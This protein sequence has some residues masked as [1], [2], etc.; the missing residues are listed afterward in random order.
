MISGFTFTLSRANGWVVLRTGLPYAFDGVNVVSQEEEREFDKTGGYLWRW[1]PW[2]QIYMQAAGFAV[3]GQDTAAGRVPFA[4]AALVVCNDSGLMHVAAALDRPLV[5]LY[6]SSSPGF[7]PPL[8]ARAQ[9]VT[10]DL[11]CSP[12]FARECPLGH[13]DCL[14]KLEP[15]RVLAVCLTTLGQQ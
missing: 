8:S 10:L 9:I 4:L 12:C 15:A 5:A 11:A 3:G 14:N 1:S 13:F 2:I 7:T 6:G